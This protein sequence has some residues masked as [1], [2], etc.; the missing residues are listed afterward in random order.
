MILSMVAQVFIG[1][2]ATMVDFVSCLLCLLWVT[3]LLIRAETS[4][5]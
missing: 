2:L 3:A 5:F 1:C 4:R